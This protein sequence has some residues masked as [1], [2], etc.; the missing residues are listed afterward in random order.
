M[1]KYILSA[2]LMLICCYKE[3]TK[4]LFRSCVSAMTP[5][6]KQT[7]ETAR[8]R[9]NMREW[10]N[11]WE[12][13]REYARHGNSTLPF[14][15]FIVCNTCCLTIAHSIKVRDSVMCIGDTY[16]K[17]WL[18]VSRIH[19]HRTEI[20]TCDVCISSTA[21][22]KWE[23][24]NTWIRIFYLLDM[25]IECHSIRW[26]Y[27]SIPLIILVDFQL[28]YVRRFRSHFSHVF[29]QPKNWVF[30]FWGDIFCPKIEVVS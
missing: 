27:L 21:R 15:T 20:R 5:E 18:Y 1:W 29:Q 16:N 3:A 12:R 26:K 24:S 4:L 8:N 17:L 30:F 23:S 7:T 25:P 14:L 28:I 19:S 13:K 11:E 22:I 6:Y 9:T 2:S 10:E